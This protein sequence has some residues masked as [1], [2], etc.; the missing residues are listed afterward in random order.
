M[1][2]KQREPREQKQRGST[3]TR[4]DVLAYISEHPEATKRDLARHFDLK[5]TDKI[6]LKRML[7]ELMD[8]GDVKRGR[9]KKLLRT[10]DLPEV[11]VVEVIDVTTDGELICRPAQ[12][13]QDG[14]PP[15]IILAPGA[16]KAIE[17]PALGIGERILAR[18]KPT[19]EGYD[20]RIIKRLGANVAKDARR[21]PPHGQTR[22]P[23]R[24]RR[25]EGAPRI[26]RRRH[27]HERRS[28]RRTR[29]RRT[30]LGPRLGP[31]AKRASPNASA[32]CRRPRPSA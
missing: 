26:R 19:Y 1:N 29:R 2:K 28:R 3:P 5:G 16:D 22:R 12:W 25:Q 18:L 20:A 27:R 7:R 4:A 14:K 30:A 32:A 23:H 15:R 13:D 21:L 31:T 24:T 6:A 8:E 9:G 17:G 11:T 10:G